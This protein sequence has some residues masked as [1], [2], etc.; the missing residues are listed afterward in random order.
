MPKSNQAKSIAIDLDD[1]VVETAQKILEYYNSKYETTIRLEQYY[2]RDFSGVW[3]AP[4]ADTAIRRV[5]G[6][7]DTQ[8]YRALVPVKEAIGAIRAL[9]EK[10]D[11]HIVTGRPDFTESATREWLQTHFPDIFEHVL[12]TNFFSYSGQPTISKAEICKKIGATHLIDDHLHHA[13][14]AEEA[15]ICVLLFGN[16]PWNKV[17][18]LPKNMIRVNNWQ[19]VL[20]YFSV[21]TV[22]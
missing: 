2:S 21:E 4:D 13:F 19:E 17:K 11:L 18:T 3:K 1:V 8:E 15:G 6:Y 10:Y 5:N 12:F 20:E 7:L 9:A 22:K 14:E 16:Y